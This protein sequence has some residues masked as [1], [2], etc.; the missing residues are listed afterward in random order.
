MNINLLSL[1]TNILLAALIMIDIAL[2][3][4]V[5]SLR[6]TIKSYLNVFP[7]EKLITVHLAN[8]TIVTL[9]IFTNLAIFIATQIAART[10]EDHPGP[11]ERVV[12]WTIEIT[13]CYMDIFMMYLVWKFA[14][15]DL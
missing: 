14:R 4:S 10:I 15:V 3:Y 12:L 5:Y 11:K 13:D 1:H 2:F 6:R 9:L 8:F 7:N